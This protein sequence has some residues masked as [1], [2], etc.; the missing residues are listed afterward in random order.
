MDI[1]AIILITIYRLSYLTR[2]SEISCLILRIE[3]NVSD[4][5][6]TVSREYFGYAVFFLSGGSIKQI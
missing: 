5:S 1:T 3:K 2:T 4:E 6:E